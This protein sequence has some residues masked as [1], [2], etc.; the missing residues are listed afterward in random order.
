M[1][2]SPVMTEA[3]VVAEHGSVW[4]R[5]AHGFA[6]KYGLRRKLTYAE[7]MQLEADLAAHLR[8]AIADLASARGAL[9]TVAQ[10]DAWAQR[11]LEQ[12]P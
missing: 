8:H 6:M 4:E 11:W 2:D 3:M 10:W 9:E 1:S 7:A 5:I 12:N